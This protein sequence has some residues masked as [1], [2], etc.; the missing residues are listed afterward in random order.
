[1]KAKFSLIG[2][3]LLGA[4]ALAACEVIN[5]ADADAGDTVVEKPQFTADGQLVRPENY[6][7]WI[8]VGSPLT[9][10]ALNGGEAGFPEFHN[11]YIQPS[12]YKIYKKTGVFP[13]GTIF[14]KELQ[15]VLRSDHE[16]GSANEASGRGYFPGAFN[17][18]DVAVKDSAR[19]PD[20]NGWGYFN[21]GHHAP[22]LAKTAKA[23][24]AEACAA[25]HIASATKDM[26]FTKF[27]TRLQ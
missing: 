21:F 14:Y 25:C 2:A 3:S 27:Y 15:L 8:Y 5:T 16:D 11:V 10:N 18:A 17:G 6:Y 4:L 7:E 19:F 24:P 13:E 23:L 20:T 12:A 22:P 1:M 9:P 26:V